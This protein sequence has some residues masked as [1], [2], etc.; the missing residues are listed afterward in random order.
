MRAINVG[1]F[2]LEIS[3]A[4]PGTPYQF[5]LADGLCVSDPTSRFQPHDVHGPSEVIDPHAYVWGKQTGK[6]AHGWRPFFTN[7]MSGH[8]RRRARSAPQP[9]AWTSL[10]IS[11]VTAVELVPITDFPGER[12][13]GYDG[14][15]LFAP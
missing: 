10:P 9:S 1:W 5:V 4:G 13:W 15:F 2:E 12:N 14:V 3:G 7:C 8:S 11:C 6:A